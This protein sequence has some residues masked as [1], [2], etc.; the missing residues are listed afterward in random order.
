MKQNVFISIIVPVYNV[1]RHLINCIKSIENQDYENWELIAIDDGSTDGSGELLDFLGKD[2]K[3]I[4]VLHIQNAGVSNARNCGLDIAKGDYIG[5]VDSDDYIDSGMYSRLVDIALKENSDIVQCGYKLVDSFYNPTVKNSKQA[6]H[7]IGRKDIINNFC[8]KKINNSLCN[9]IFKRTVINDIRINTDYRTSEDGLFV[10][11]C[12]KK[13][14]KITVIDAELYFYYQRIDS[15][16]HAPIN[17]KRMDVFTFLDLLKDENKN[18]IK[19][20]TSIVQRELK[21]CL[22]YYNEILLSLPYKESDKYM[23]EIRNRMKQHIVEIFKIK[24]YGWIFKIR[25]LMICITPKMYK[26]IYK[27]Y[28]GINEVGY[29]GKING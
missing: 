21:T 18:D 24:K 3:H 19:L 13:C 27:R 16:T 6:E 20:W 12:C 22:D 2:N 4:K 10:Y 26:R 7:I 23:A 9:K 1:K 25:I 11:E 15:V 29:D 14:K 5:F 28:T 17:E 8:D